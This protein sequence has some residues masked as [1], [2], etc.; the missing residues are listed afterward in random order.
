MDP[1]EQLLRPPP[2][3]ARLAA[4]ADALLARVDLALTRVAQLEVEAREAAQELAWWGSAFAIAVVVLLALNV[5]L[6]MG[7]PRQ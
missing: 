6:L 5:L 3:L 1:I 4:K 7:R 2:E